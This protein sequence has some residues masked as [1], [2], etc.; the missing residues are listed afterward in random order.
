[1]SITDMKKNKVQI[2][3]SNLAAAD[4]YN[5]VMNDKRLLD[6]KIPSN[7]SFA[8]EKNKSGKEM[9]DVLNKIKSIKPLD[10]KT[11][12]SGSSDLSCIKKDYFFIL[13]KRV[14]S[15]QKEKK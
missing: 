4:N 7:G 8:F 9:A 13:E 5:F 3:N 12:G 15:G 11:F 6:E 10:I 1:M 14:G 2:T